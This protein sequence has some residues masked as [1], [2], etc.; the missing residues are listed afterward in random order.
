MWVVLIILTEFLSKILTP[1]C[2]CPKDMRERGLGRLGRGAPRDS[3]P[4]HLGILRLVDDS[5]HVSLAAQKEH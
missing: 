4:L 1:P 3:L 5:D 2:R